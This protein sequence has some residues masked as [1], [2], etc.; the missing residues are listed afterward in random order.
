MDAAHIGPLVTYAE[1][2][3]LT[4]GLPRSE[5]YREVSRVLE[6]AVRSLAPKDSVNRQAP[7]LVG[8]K[9]S[10]GAATRLTAD[11]VMAVTET[12]AEEKV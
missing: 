12:R 10:K 8:A 6:L 4:Q 3:K 2:R 1:L 7:P 9:G 11:S 5:S